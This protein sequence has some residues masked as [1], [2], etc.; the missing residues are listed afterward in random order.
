MVE[1]AIGCKTRNIAPN[2]GCVC[3][4]V[5]F[6]FCAENGNVFLTLVLN[7]TQSSH[8]GVNEINRERKREEYNLVDQISRDWDTYQIPEKMNNVE[9]EE[10]KKNDK[11][12]VMIKAKEEEE[13]EEEKKNDEM[14]T[15]AFPSI[16]TA[17]FEFDV[18]KAMTVLIDE[19]KYL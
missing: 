4:C 18:E 10:S 19:V 12:K 13:Q 14:H 17:T 15:L 2:T 9:K 1:D 5:C 11:E 6:F 3:V 16:S 8:P 7:K